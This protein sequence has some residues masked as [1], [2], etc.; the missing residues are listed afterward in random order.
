MNS[1]K[2]NIRDR[3]RDATRE[4]RR[5]VEEGIAKGMLRPGDKLPNERV[6]AEQFHAGRNTVRR[7]M[8][9]LEAENKLTRHVGRGTFVAKNAESDAPPR[10]IQGSE[11]VDASGEEFFL[12]VAKKASP[13]DL[14]ELRLTIE[15]ELAALAAMRAGGNEIDRMQD[16]VDR[17]RVVAS[18]Q[19]FEDCDDELHRTVALCSRNPLFIAIAEIITVVRNA[20]EWG[21][22]KERTLTAEA[23]LK[24]LGEHV[25]IVSAIRQRNAMRARER[26]M[27]HLQA[28]KESMTSR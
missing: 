22:L 18:L 4:I 15:P 13:L 27:L 20:G 7:V 11:A 5:F 17:S 10:E 19:D 21:R 9:I 16:A 23:R 26:M 2:E 24:H 14:M 3:S 25:E 1:M 12:S 28:I 8:S 6:L